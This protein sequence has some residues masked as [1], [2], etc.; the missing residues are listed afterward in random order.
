MIGL[1]AYQ[2]AAIRILSAGIVLMPVVIKKM[3]FFPKRTL[4]KILLSGLLGSFFPAFLFCI[5]ETRIDSSLAGFLNAFTP[6]LTIFIG[7]L[8]FHVPLEKNKLPGIFL[9]FA[10][11]LLLFLATGTQ[12]MKE[13]WFA[14]LV[15]V[16]TIS[17]AVNVNMVGKYLKE[18]GPID[19]ASFAFVMLIIPSLVL[20]ILTGFFSLSFNDEAVQLSI[21][22]S[23]VLGV[24]GTAVASITF[25][26]LL[27]RAGVVFSSMVT[28]GIPFV[29]LFWGILAGETV[30]A[31][32]I[33]G[34]AVILAG[35]YLTS[36][37][38]W[39]NK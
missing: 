27:R 13:V 38:I 36:K 5:A 9:G 22:A 33:A 29:A 7:M 34:L 14:I 10:G 20:L 3:K 11:M 12:S 19:I 8:F 26:I 32:Q 31:M 39:L 2:V 15:V 24:L 4:G 25:Y 30:I 35:V 18:V 6:I 37:P 23:V 16:A 17:Y 28:Y 21:M 1:T